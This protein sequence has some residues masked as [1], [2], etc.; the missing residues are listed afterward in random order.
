[1]ESKNK[2]SNAGFG[3]LQHSLS[4]IRK[5]Q[6]EIQIAC[7]FRKSANTSFI[8]SGTEQEKEGT[9]HASA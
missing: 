5:E 1:M 7:G 4:A 2:D 8:Y 3:V 6:Q 9:P